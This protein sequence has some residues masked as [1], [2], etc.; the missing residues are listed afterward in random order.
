MVDK[1]LEIIIIIIIIVMI[2]INIFLYKTIQ[3]NAITTT[4]LLSNDSFY[5]IKVLILLY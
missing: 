5:N 4:D 2:I 3:T 1:F